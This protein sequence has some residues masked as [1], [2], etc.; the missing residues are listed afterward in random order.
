MGGTKY[1]IDSVFFDGHRKFIGKMDFF[2]IRLMDIGF[3]VMAIIPLYSIVKDEVGEIIH[4]MELQKKFG[5]M[6]RMKRNTKNQ[7]HEHSPKK[8]IATDYS[9]NYTD[10]D[11]QSKSTNDQSGRYFLLKP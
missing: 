10:E 2:W 11:M 6:L 3:N 4:K 9:G 1:F 7:R 5:A 8:E